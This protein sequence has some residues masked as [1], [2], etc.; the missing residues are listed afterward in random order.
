[1][2]VHPVHP[3][4]DADDAGFPM[5]NG[6]SLGRES[7]IPASGA[8]LAARPHANGGRQRPIGGGFVSSNPDPV[9]TQVDACCGQT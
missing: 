6:R 7:F 4:M 8:E 1:M 5:L 9:R 2:P 3:M